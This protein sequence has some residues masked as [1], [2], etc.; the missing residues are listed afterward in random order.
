M[1]LDLAVEHLHSEQAGAI[2]FFR[3]NYSEVI[4]M[5]IERKASNKSIG[6]RKMVLGVGLND[7]NYITHGPNETKCPFYTKWSSMLQR[8]YSEKFLEQRPTYKGCE[9]C[10]DWLTFSN[11]KSWMEKQDWKNKELDKDI[12]FKGNKVYSPLTCLF[13]DPKINSALC[14]KKSKSTGLYVGISKDGEKYKA[15]CNV[16]GKRVYL[17]LF[18]SESKAV[19]AYKE[20]KERSIKRMA[21]GQNEP[22]RTAMLKFIA[23]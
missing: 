14:F 19:A 7:A 4:N 22:L 9:V 13:V 5:F 16:N 17:G 11:F 23:S 2:I 3:A 6:Q 21:A 10:D 20:A 8:C 15:R 12:L 18:D 1:R